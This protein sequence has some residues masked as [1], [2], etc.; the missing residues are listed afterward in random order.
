[1]LP[2]KEISKAYFLPEPF[3]L[4]NVYSELAVSI[5]YMIN[6]IVVIVGG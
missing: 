1:M 4:L 2:Y 3:F 6:F 5:K